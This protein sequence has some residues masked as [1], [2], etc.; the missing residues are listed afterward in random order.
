MSEP[1]PYCERCDLPLAQ[2]VHSLRAPA[3]LPTYADGPV[4]EA[5]IAGFCT[6]CGEHFDRGRMIVHTETGW[7]IATHTKATPLPDDGRDQF[8]GFE[9]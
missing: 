4:I 3:R 2:C 9:I 8:E 1:E 6:C 5:Q 7:A